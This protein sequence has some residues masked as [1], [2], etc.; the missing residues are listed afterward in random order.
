MSLGFH[1]RRP[2]A[3]VVALGIG[4]AGFVLPVVSLPVVDRAPVEP[5]E[6][7]IAL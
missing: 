4:I 5:T 1:V 2:L 3:C 6:Q 7:T